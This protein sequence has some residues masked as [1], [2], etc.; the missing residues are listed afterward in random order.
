MGDT[1]PHDDNIPRRNN[2]NNLKIEPAKICHVFWKRWEQSIFQNIFSPG[3]EPE[4][5][6]TKTF[7]IST[8]SPIQVFLLRDLF[9]F[10]F[11]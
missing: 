10:L 9:L 8:S 6:T 11:E 1:Q 2:C 3:I 4:L 7:F 5:C